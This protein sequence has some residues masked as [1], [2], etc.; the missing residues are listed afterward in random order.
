MAGEA[1]PS[2][3]CETLEEYQ[4]D[5]RIAC[6]YGSKCY[7][8][9]PVH[10][11]KYKHPP[12]GK[13][14]VKKGAKRFKKADSPPKDE[15][16]EPDSDNV[17]AEI[18]DASSGAHSPKRKAVKPNP[19]T[20]TPSSSKQTSS[21]C[22]SDEPS[23]KNEEN[24][25]PNFSDE[26]EM[27][28]SPSDMRQSIKQ[29]FLFEMPEDFYS[30]WEFC[31]TLNGL[32][33]A[34]AFRDIGLQL[35]GPYDVLSSHFRVNKNMRK[36]SYYLLHWRYYYDPPGFQTVLKG[37]DKKQFHVGYFRDDPKSMPAFLASNCAAKDGVFTQMAENIFGAVNVLLNDA[38]KT[39]TPFSQPKISKLQK[40]L[41]GYAEE[42]GFTLEHKT[43]AMKQRDRR[44]VSKTF[45]GLGLLVPVEKKTEV[46]YRELLETD[47]NLKRILNRIVE[48]ERQ[49]L[50][51]K[52][53]D[54]LQQVVTAANIANDE[55]DFGTS[56]ELGLDLFAY[57]G[58]EFERTALQ[59][60][61]TGYSLLGRPEFAK[62]AQVHISNRRRP[63]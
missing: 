9:N 24:D 11:N 52:A 46:G 4:S 44:T 33:P 7:Q 16:N 1:G 30:F 63:T 34:M 50:K 47:A 32:N 22:T 49:D 60:L 19:P 62:V 39:A 15:A 35:V 17:E 12:K 2:L 61:S 59:L 31:Q 42:C 3:N 57:G 8:K 53:L 43:Q 36:Q 10:I 51:D 21:D 45:N 28:P 23:A 58:T 14:P 56:V 18:S 48:S 5:S 29:K 37:D 25:V 20:D 6:K 38:K 27:P 55:C 13:A 41:Q 54:Q 26:P 40:A